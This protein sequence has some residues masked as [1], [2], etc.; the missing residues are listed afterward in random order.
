MHI[1]HP[2]MQTAGKDQ[3]RVMFSGW[4]VN[5]LFFT[6][7]WKTLLKYTKTRSIKTTLP[8]LWTDV[9]LFLIPFGLMS[10]YQAQRVDWSVIKLFKPSFIAKHFE[11]C[12]LYREAMK[13]ILTEKIRTRKDSC[14]RSKTYRAA[15]GYKA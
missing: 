13:G 7:K 6:L 15:L 9:I 2:I 14:N 3:I 8:Q 10:V 4:G 12:L 5:Y 11:S 1:E